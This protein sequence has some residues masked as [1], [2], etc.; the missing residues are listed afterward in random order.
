MDDDS[1]ATTSDSYRWRE[2]NSVSATAVVV[3]GGGGVGVVGDD[4]TLSSFVGETGAVVTKAG[5]STNGVL[6]A[7]VATG[8][9]AASNCACLIAHADRRHE[10]R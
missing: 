5:F 3:V 7:P 6:S 1:G 10:D 4:E 2:T 8:A 9:V